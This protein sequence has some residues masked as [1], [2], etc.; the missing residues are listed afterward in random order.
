M[1][2]ARLPTMPRSTSCARNSR[3]EKEAVLGCAVRGGE[4]GERIPEGKHRQPSLNSNS[5]WSTSLL[6]IRLED[7]GASL[8]E[9]PDLCYCLSCGVRR[10][11]SR[12]AR[13]QN[14]SVDSK[15][16]SATKIPRNPKNP[17]GARD[18]ISSMAGRIRILSVHDGGRQPMAFSLRSDTNARKTGIC[19][20]RRSGE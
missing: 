13:P 9:P 8:E 19:E 6:G 14:P 2:S 16:S 1:C 20:I 4:E 18:K 5:R 3:D 10:S 17:R 15:K 7:G 12:K 11:Q